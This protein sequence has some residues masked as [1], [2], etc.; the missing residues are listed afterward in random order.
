MARRAGCQLNTAIRVGEERNGER[1]AKNGRE[2]TERKNVTRNYGQA[3]SNQ[4]PRVTCKHPSQRRLPN[5]F[6]RTHA[7]LP[8]SPISNTHIHTRSLMHSRTSTNTHTHT[9]SPTFL[10]P[11]MD[12]H[13]YTLTHR[14]RS[15]KL[16]L[17]MT[18]VFIRLSKISFFFFF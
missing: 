13:S 15:A 8:S 17:Q 3:L 7:S 14:H 6:H 18:N 1:N 5:P 9:Q 4:G 16:Q 2:G 10:F 11:H 12:S